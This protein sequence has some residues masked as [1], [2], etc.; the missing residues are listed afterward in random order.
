MY[1]QFLNELSL[2]KRKKSLSNLEEQIIQM[3]EEGL[4]YFDISEKVSYDASYVGDVSRELYGMVAEKYKLKVTRSNLFACINRIVYNDLSQSKVSANIHEFR[5]DRII[6][7]ISKWW[8]YNSKDNSLILKNENTLVF[9]LEKLTIE[10]LGIELLKLSSK[11]QL[12]GKALLELCQIL[13]NFFYVDVDTS[14]S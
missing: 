4:T 8:K 7:D 12:C 10:S 6:L 14:H 9:L 3:L 2:E 13:N 11:E 1:I 5:N